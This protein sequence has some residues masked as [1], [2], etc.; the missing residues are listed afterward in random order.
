MPAEHVLVLA[1]GGASTESGRAWR[2]LSSSGAIAWEGTLLE[3]PSRPEGEALV[4]GRYNPAA[5][6]GAAAGAG[7]AE[8]NVPA[9]PK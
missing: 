6:A 2:E 5:R 3:N 1:N 8:A 4:Y 7:L 9:T